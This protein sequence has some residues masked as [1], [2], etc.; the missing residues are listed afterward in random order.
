MTW[1][2]VAHTLAAVSQPRIARFAGGYPDRS[3]NRQNF[4]PNT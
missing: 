4:P 3:S 2:S 1:T